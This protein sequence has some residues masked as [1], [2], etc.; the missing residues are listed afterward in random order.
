[1]DHRVFLCPSCRKASHFDLD[2]PRHMISQRNPEDDLA[3]A[4]AEEGPS[5]RLLKCRN[6]DCCAPFEVALCYNNDTAQR[7]QR[8]LQDISWASPTS[9]FLRM[10]ENGT[11]DRRTCSVAFNRSPVKRWN[12]LLISKLMDPALLKQLVLGF[13]VAAGVPLAAFEAFHT[14]EELFWIPMEPDKWAQESLSYRTPV[15]DLCRIAAREA[16]EEELRTLRDRGELG[17][18]G[19]RHWKVCPGRSCTPGHGEVSDVCLR[20]LELWK[21]YDPCYVS[22]LKIIAEVTSRFE[23]SSAEDAML[24]ALPV[25]CWRDQLEVAFP[26]I[27]QN[28]LVAVVMTGRFRRPDE[29]DDADKIIEASRE[30]REKMGMESTPDVLA[31]RRE[32]LEQACQADP[33]EAVIRTSEDIESLSAPE[34][35]LQKMVSWLADIA[36]RRIDAK[37]SVIEAAFREELSGRMGNWMSE[38]KE[39]SWVVSEVLGQMLT[40][41]AFKR[42][43]VLTGAEWEETVRLFS[44]DGQ[45]VWRKNIHVTLSDIP[46]GLHLLAAGRRGLENQKKLE[47]LFQF[48]DR[49]REVFP[50]ADS[51]PFHAERLTA[52]IVVRGGDRRHVFVFSERDEKQLFKIPVHPSLPGRE[53]TDFRLSQECRRH[54]RDACQV[55]ADQLRHFWHGEDQEQTFRALAHT[56]RNPIAIM[57][58]GAIALRRGIR[59]NQ[60]E[61]SKDWPKL[62]EAMRE[63]VKGM[64]IA[65]RLLNDEL[66]KYRASAKIESVL[67]EAGE[68]N[69]ELC[70]ILHE[71]KSQYDFMAKRSGKTWELLAP[72]PPECRVIGK[73]EPIELAI[74][75]IAENAYK[76]GFNRS[77]VKV[78]LVTRSVGEEDP[79][80]EAEETVLRMRNHGVRIE[81]DEL[82]KIRQKGVRGQHA[83]AR[84]SVNQAGTGLGMYLVDRVMAAVGGRLDISCENTSEDGGW[85]CVELTFKKWAPNP[86]K[87]TAENG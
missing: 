39:I 22:D 69:T 45:D 11:Q 73:Q 29:E 48:M 46:S 19:C 41:W 53:Q 38:R 20:R 21:R 58:N 63:A 55:V 71:L 65:R 23:G 47:P 72:L 57:Q 40:F 43:C 26:V 15:C 74:R 84:K 50:R 33:C 56:M 31:L 87:E 13:S 2:L 64:D 12:R 81:S 7:I 10:D 1:V 83:Q 76:Y 6:P 17:E 77:T 66:G 37:R 60:E 28:H 70:K 8:R 44:V 80:N 54:M 52:A 75:N 59:E 14:G 61:L 4:L 67:A 27:A 24:P 79:E 78:E 35:H 5:R 16:A 85:V 42:G 3:A 86:R 32:E 9:F 25:R 34:A 18:N 30:Y 82:D 68:G 49:L 51:E 62:L 36:Q